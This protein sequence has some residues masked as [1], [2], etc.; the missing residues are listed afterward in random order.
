[1]IVDNLSP[2]GDCA[3]ELDG[4]ESRTGPLSTMTGALIINMIRC[5]TARMLLSQGKTPVMLPSHQFVDKRDAEEQLENFYEQY[6]LSMKHLY[7]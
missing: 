7:E 1:V 3:V 5:E 2:I 4:L 6:R